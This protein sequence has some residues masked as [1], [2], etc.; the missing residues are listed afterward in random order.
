MFIIGTHVYRF[1]AIFFILIKVHGVTCQY[2]TIKMD[3]IEKFK[4]QNAII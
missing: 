1:K 4:Y 3:K 2:T